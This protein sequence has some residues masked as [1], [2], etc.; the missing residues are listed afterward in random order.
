VYSSFVQITYELYSFTSITFTPCGYTGTGGPIISACVSTY[1]G[2]NS[3]VSNTSNFNMTRTGYQLWT[4]PKTSPYTIVCAGAGANGNGGAGNGAVQ[5]IIVRLVKGDIYQIAVGQGGTYGGGGNCGSNPRGGSGGSFV[6]SNDSSTIIVISG[7][8]GGYGNN[9]T[10]IANANASLTTS[11]NKDTDNNGTGGSA[12]YGGTG[13]G[14]N[15]VNN[16]TSCC[17]QGAGGAGFLGNGANG[18]NG[19]SGGGSF[20]NGLYGGNTG[21]DGV[22]SYGGFGGGG[23]ASYAG[24]GGGGYSGGAGGNLN[25]CNCGDCQD[26][27]GGG[28]YSIVTPNSTSVDNTGQG[29]VSVTKTSFAAPATVTV[30]TAS[31]STQTVIVKW[32]SSGAQTY[33]LTIYQNSSNSTSGGTQIGQTTTA[34]LTYTFTSLSLTTG[35]YVYATVYA[36]SDGVTTSATTSSTIQ[37]VAVTYINY[38][39]TTFFANTGSI[40]DRSGPTIAGGNGS[41]WGSIIQSAQALNPILFGNNHGYIVAGYSNYSC[42]TSGYIYSASVGTIQFYGVTDDGLIVNFNGTNVIDQYQQ[43]GATGYNSATV[44]LPAGYTPI[45]IT[46]Y[47]TGGGGQYDIYYTVNGGTQTSDGTGLTYHRS[48]ATY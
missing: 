13:S 41:N 25:S 26:G 43:Q 29:Y 4:V 15:L 19:A 32:L 45:R 7:G 42:L 37:V 34:N 30:T 27:G 1:S 2:S 16:G 22:N 12:G 8:G 28:S 35:Y 23:G 17:C 48:D 38:L 10:T 24:G 21:G 9:R 39:Y 14:A 18:Y 20:A 5:T 44:T 40:P 36:Y 6:V 46:W 31:S 3:W 11:G 33:T 47:D